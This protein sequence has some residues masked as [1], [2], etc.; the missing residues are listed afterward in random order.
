LLSISG[1]LEA[2]EAAGAARA[3]ALRQRGPVWIYYVL[4]LAL[5]GG[6]F[7]AAL[8]LDVAFEMLARRRVIE[9]TLAGLG[10]LLIGWV[11][12]VLFSRPWSIRRF[13]R[14]MEDRGLSRRFPYSVTVDDQGLAIQS[15]RIR[16]TAEWASVTEVFKARS[17]WVFLVQMEAWVAPA[18]LFP[19]L[20]AERA[21]IAAALAR[22]S[23]GARKRSPEAVTFAAT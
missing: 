9:P 13:R 20:A 19:D 12:Y 7:L 1:D 23:E 21:F 15:G 3:I 2:G 8:G 10:G 17:Y 14:R 16:K 18:R 22:M 5:M 4:L 11:V 6:F